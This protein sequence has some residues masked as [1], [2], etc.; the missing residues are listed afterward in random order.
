[1]RP[2]PV[3]ALAALVFTVSA[4]RE[5]V[6]QPPSQP[7]PR[8][9][10]I[11]LVPPDVELGAEFHDEEY[12]F[13]LRLPKGMTP[14]TGAELEEARASTLVPE[15]ELPVLDGKPARA[16][17]W[18]FKHEERGSIL[19]LMNEPP[20]TIDSPTQLRHAMAAEDR[21]KGRPYENVGKLYE[22][23]AR[24]ARSGFLITR[25]FGIEPGKP[26]TFRQHVAYLRGTQKSFL[27]RYVAPKEDFERLGEDFKASMI[28]FAIERGTQAPVVQN[29]GTESKKPEFGST[30][31][32]LNVALLVLLAVG[33]LVW[34]RKSA[35]TG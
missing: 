22:F 30:R 21:A 13:L 35:A 14:V 26:M 17:I 10:S 29:T 8:V 34:W 19:V 24:G 32:I 9:A 31:S 6:A 1:M 27:I 18:V 20:V 23:K 15:S 3:L 28:T 16:Q 4:A 7:A 12:G 11:P 5:G 2:R 33:G 25:D